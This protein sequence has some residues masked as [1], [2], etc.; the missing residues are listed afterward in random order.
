MGRLMSDDKIK[1]RTSIPSLQEKVKASLDGATDVIYWN[2]RFNIAL[3]EST[4]SE[5]TMHVTDTDG[6]IMRT[7]ISFNKNNNVIVISPL[8]TY[9]QNR[10]Y[11]LNISKK[12]KSAKGKQMRSSIHILFKLLD[13]E[14]SNYQ[15]LKKTAKVPHPKPRPKDYDLKQDSR[16]QNA[17]DIYYSQDNRRDHMVALSYKFNIWIGIAGLAVTAVGVYLNLFWII[18]AGTVI[19]I[20]GLAHVY[21]QLKNDEVKFALFFNSGVR[22]YNKGRYREAEVSFIKASRA[23]PENKLAKH[24]IY[25]SNLYKNF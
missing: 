21:I 14:I 15:V 25:K 7:D 11:M 6:Y 4:V 19:C 23:N 16:L 17:F 22:K 3:D 1:I 10:F 5:K 18:I 12:V 20:C 8:D 24:A 9:E 2:I 13:N